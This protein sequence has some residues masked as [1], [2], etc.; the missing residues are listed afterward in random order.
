MKQTQL[1][2]NPKNGK[3]YRFYRICRLRECEKEIYTNYKHKIFCLPEHQQL[4]WQRIREGDRAV[5]DEVSR[6]GKRIAQLE[7][8]LGMD[9]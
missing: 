4:Y 2:L 9:K 1:Y 5:M 6:Q 7:K 3:K 8:K